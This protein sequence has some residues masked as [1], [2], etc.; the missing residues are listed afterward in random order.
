MTTRVFVVDD[1]ELVRRGLIELIDTED[2]LT[3]VGQAG[4]VQEALTTLGTLTT[5]VAVL[6]VR[7]P[8]GS[9]IELCREI[10]SLYPDIKVLMLT[11]FLDDEAVLGAVLGGASGYVI[12]DIKNLDLLEA[13]RKVAV[14]EILLDIAL[15]STV[16]NRLRKAASPASEIYEL[17]DQEQ[18]VLE[19]IGRGFTNRQIAES[20]FL[21]EKTIKNYVSS[22]LGKLGLERRTQAAALAARLGLGRN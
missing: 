17:T 1:H 11:S 19:H 16:T 12:K 22:L 10:R 20:M 8:D 13:I 7:L 21:A 14:G 5:D 2:D 4:D 6:D 9:G 18:R 15:I 3:V